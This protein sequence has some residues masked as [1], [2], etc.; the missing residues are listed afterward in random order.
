V[1]SLP[2][3]FQKTWEKLG[4][5]ERGE[6]P[7]FFVLVFFGCWF[8]VVLGWVLSKNKQNFSLHKKREEK[9]FHS[10]NC[11]FGMRAEEREK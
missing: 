8:L 5:R 3:L 1:R 4:Y 7:P 6:S 9:F 2:S 10:I 11:V